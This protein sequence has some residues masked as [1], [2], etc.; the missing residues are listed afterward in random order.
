MTI[1][2]FIYRTFWQMS[3]KKEIYYFQRKYSTTN[4]WLFFSS[5]GTTNSSIMGTSWR[6][7]SIRSCNKLSFP[8][9]PF[10][11]RICITYN[12]RR[13]WC[14]WGHLLLWSTSL[15]Y[16]DQW[17]CGLIHIFFRGQCSGFFNWNLLP[18]QEAYGNQITL[19]I[20]RVEDLVLGDKNFRE[21]LVIR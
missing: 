6:S 4:R 7:Q 15:R 10:I 13:H 18:F 1:N 5:S 8:F 12:S 14:T 2:E 21:S 20:S 17:G 3:L 11:Y 19:R 16:R 9:Y